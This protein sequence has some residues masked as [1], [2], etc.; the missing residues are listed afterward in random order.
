M[1]NF[2][3]RLPQ[4]QATR[5]IQAAGNAVL[6]GAVVL[7]PKFPNAAQVEGLRPVPLLKP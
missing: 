3:P 7:N 2:F 4:D 6:A 1:C 5:L